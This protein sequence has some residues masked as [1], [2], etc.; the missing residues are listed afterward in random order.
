MIMMFGSIPRKSI[1]FFQPFYATETKTPKY[2]SRNEVYSLYAYQRMAET[3]PNRELNQKCSQ[4][5][6]WE[7]SVDYYDRDGASDSL[8]SLQ[9]RHDLDINLILLALWTG[10]EMGMLLKKE[11]FAILDA[12]AY[13]W[14]NN[15]IKPLRSCRQAIKS[16]T[17]MNIGLTDDIYQKLKSAELDAEHVAQI[18]LSGSLSSLPETTNTSDYCHAATSNLASYFA[19]AD[20]NKNQ[21]VRQAAVFLI[22]CAEIK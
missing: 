13:E 16:F 11:H 14:R 12:E 5:S 8:L 1:A 10:A 18:F 7:Y 17:S 2:L 22:R 4:T 19:Y 3:D 9:N 6:F 15:I 21:K 20:V